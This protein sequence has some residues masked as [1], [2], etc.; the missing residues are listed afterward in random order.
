MFAVLENVDAMPGVTWR[1]GSHENRF[2]PVV[3]DEFLE[4]RVRAFTPASFRQRRNRSG[5]RSLTATTSTL[6]WS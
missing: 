6:G 2:D 3:L 5:K 1:I 4:R